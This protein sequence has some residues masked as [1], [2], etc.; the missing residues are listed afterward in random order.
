MNRTSFAW[1]IVSAAIGISACA[2][3]SPTASEQPASNRLVKDT[4]LPPPPVIVGGY[5]DA[6]PANTANADETAARNLAVAELY[7][8]F[9]TRAL[10]EKVTVQTQVVAGL[11]YRFHITMSGGAAYD[12]VVYRDLQNH[13]TITGVDPA[14]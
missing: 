1:L 6:G 4:A 14:K 2:R 11:N 3:H 8:K 9:P 13:M 7:R 12:V 10:V 5:T